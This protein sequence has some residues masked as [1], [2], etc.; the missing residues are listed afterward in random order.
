MCGR[1]RIP[2]ESLEHGVRQGVDG[3][4]LDQETYDQRFQ[5]ITSFI[6][7]AYISFKYPY[8]TKFVILSVMVSLRPSWNSVWILADSP[9]LRHSCPPVAAPPHLDAF[10]SYQA[11]T[12]HKATS[13]AWDSFVSVALSIDLFRSSRSSC[14]V[15]MFR[16]SVRRLAVAAAKAAEPSAHTIAVSQAQGVSRG[17]TGGS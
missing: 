4:S 6:F 15:P 16:H 13:L 8:L 9:G 12:L 7:T 14:S 5:D 10:P 2:L 17:L 3:A 11:K 1:I